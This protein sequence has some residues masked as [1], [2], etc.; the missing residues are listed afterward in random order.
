MYLQM[1][2]N[3]GSLLVDRSQNTYITALR[4]AHGVLRHDFQL[5]CRKPLDASQPVLLA[6]M[7]IV[8]FALAVGVEKQRLETVASG[9]IWLSVL[10]ASMSSFDTLFRTDMEDGALEQWLISPVP[11]VW[12]IYVRIFSHW[13]STALPLI[14]ITPLLGRFITLPPELTKYL[15]LSLILGTPLLSLLGAIVAALTMT[16]KRSNLFLGILAFPLYVPVI[17]FGAGSVAAFSQGLDGSG[18]L[19]FLAAGLT[20]GITVIPWTVAAAI[21]I[22]IL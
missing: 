2:Q 4:A 1:P 12:L 14:V 10:L 11:F 22:A 20:L 21:R 3:F 9:V 17:V 7:L 5:L 8:L 13:I 6:V 15:L 19:W 16:L 18:G